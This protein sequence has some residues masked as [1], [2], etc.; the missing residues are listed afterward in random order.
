MSKLKMF[1]SA[2]GN[3]NL[4]NKHSGHLVGLAIGRVNLQI[5]VTSSRPR[6]AFN[7]H[8]RHPLFAPEGY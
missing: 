1:L 5:A 4:H 6:E 3:L 2:N 7:L 8:H